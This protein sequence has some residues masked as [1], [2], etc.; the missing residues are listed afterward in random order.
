MAIYAFDVED[1]EVNSPRG[2]PAGRFYM[3]LILE[4]TNDSKREWKL[5]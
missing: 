1:A 2:K 4:G 5:S 3:C